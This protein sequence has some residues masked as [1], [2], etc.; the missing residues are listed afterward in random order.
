[1]DF[2]PVS[3]ELCKSRS[4]FK[5]YN[6][7]YEIN[8]DISCAGYFFQISSINFGSTTDSAS[9]RYRS[10]TEDKDR[11]FL[12]VNLDKETARGKAYFVEMN[13][14]G[15]LKDDMKGLYLTTFKQGD[16]I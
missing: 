8:T 3:I 2:Q 6:N 4:T 5:E 9:P 12:I 10:H 13:F 7:A 14:V 11:Q 1:M 15:H 16:Q